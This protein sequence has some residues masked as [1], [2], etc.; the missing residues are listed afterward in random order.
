MRFSRAHELIVGRTVSLFMA[1]EQE[2][3]QDK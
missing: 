2:E 1:A 3:K